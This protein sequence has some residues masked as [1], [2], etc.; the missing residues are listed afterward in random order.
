MLYSEYIL[1]RIAYCDYPYLRNIND[2]DIYLN[3]YKYSNIRAWLNG[4]DG[5]SYKIS[6]YTNKR[7]PRGE[8]GKY[9]SV[10]RKYN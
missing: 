1:D 2:V 7:K 3:N 6:D 10:S 4:Y 5:T 9:A 8:S